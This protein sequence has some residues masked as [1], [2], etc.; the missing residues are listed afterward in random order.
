MGDKHRLM[1]WFEQVGYEQ[2]EPLDDIVAEYADLALFITD[3]VPPGAE[4]TVALRKLLE[5]REAA[6][7]AY[8][9]ARKPDPQ[10]ES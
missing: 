1:R 3:T 10:E 5:S 2:D 9:E 6:M 4:Q 8:E 7:R